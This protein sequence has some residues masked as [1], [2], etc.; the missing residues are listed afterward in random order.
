LTDYHDWLIPDRVDR[1]KKVA[2]VVHRELS[3]ILQNK[4]EDPRIGPVTI[5]EVSISSD[6]KRAKIFVVGHLEENLQQSLQLLNRASS[7]IRR[8]LADQTK[9]KYVPALEFKLDLM[10]ERSAR[11]LNLINDLSQTDKSSVYD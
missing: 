10:P 1:T 5:T 7:Y 4:V 2:S 9:L 11:V 3:S 8:R 6:L